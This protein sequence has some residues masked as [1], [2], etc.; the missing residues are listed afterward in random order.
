MNAASAVLLVVLAASAVLLFR[1][2]PSVSKRHALPKRIILIRHGE[3]V[4]NVDESIYSRVPDWRVRLSPKG[5]QQAIQAGEKL[6][7]EIGNEPVVAYVSPYHRTRETFANIALQ[8]EPQQVLE[9]RMEPRLREQDFGNFQHSER[10][11]IAKAERSQFG[12]FLF[13]FPNG[14]SGADVY[15]R[16]S[17]FL[18]TFAR[19]ILSDGIGGDTNVNAAIKPLPAGLLNVFD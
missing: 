11:Q 5:H 6:R 7:R 9:V 10:M 3:S 2:K 4:G 18:E 17:T 8:L 19:D 16:V 15:D 14:E 1:R 12:R 13:R